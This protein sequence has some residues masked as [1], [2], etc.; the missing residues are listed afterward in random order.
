MGFSEKKKK[1][2]N[3]E[4]F[5]YYCGFVWLLCTYFVS[6]LDIIVTSVTSKLKIPCGDLA[7]LKLDFY[8]CSNVCFFF[9]TS[10]GYY[11]Y[12]TV[13]TSNFKIRC[14]V[15]FHKENFSPPPDIINFSLIQPSFSFSPKN[16]VINSK[17]FHHHSRA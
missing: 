5:P 16:T 8:F 15:S 7:L 14:P 9:L 12:T 17:I 1:K 4:K 3:F 10:L 2:E 11:C 13:V 6:F